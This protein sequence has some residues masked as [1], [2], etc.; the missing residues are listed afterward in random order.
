[1]TKK[2]IDEVVSECK[3]PACELAKR[4]AEMIAQPIKNISKSKIEELEQLLS[5]LVVEAKAAKKK[6]QDPR[7]KK[8]FKALAKK[9]RELLDEIMKD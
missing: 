1:M 8:E 2:L 3:E 7:T 5:Q 9:T 6:G 4:L